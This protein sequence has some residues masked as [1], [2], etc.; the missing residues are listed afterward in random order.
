FSGVRGRVSDVSSLVSRT[1]LSAQ[2]LF[3]LRAEHAELLEQ[4]A[5]YERLERSAAEIFQ[6]NVRLREQLG[7]SQ[8]LNYS[9]IPARLV[10]RDPDN[11]Y[12]A[13]VINKGH[14]SGVARNMAVIAWQGGSQALV[15][16]VIEANAFDSLVMPLYDESLLVSSRFATSRYEGIVEGQGSVDSPLRMRY[17]P[18]RARGEISQ[19]DLVATSGMGGV[20]PPDISIGRVSGVAYREYE[21]SMEVEVEPLIDFSR[22]EYVFVIGERAGDD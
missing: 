5:R 12:S 11:L 19:G 14:R 3:R 1:A 15:G 22:L 2:E 16:K 18:K 13:L 4:V 17:I 7:F 8:E 20:Y 10:G 9:H 21:I 6:E